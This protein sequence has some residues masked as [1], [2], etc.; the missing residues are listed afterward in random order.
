MNTIE[1]KTICAFFFPWVRTGPL[2]R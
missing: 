1:K 2:R